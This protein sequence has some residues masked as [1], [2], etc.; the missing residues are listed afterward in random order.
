VFRALLIRSGDRNGLVALLAMTTLLPAFLV[1]CGRWLFWPFVPRFDPAAGGE[2]IADHR[3]WRRMAVLVGRRPRAVWSGTALALA[4][5]A[6]GALTLRFG[7]TQEQSFTRPVES[8][9]AQ[10]MLDGHYPGGLSAPA[11]IYATAASADAVTAAA[12]GVDGVAS[13]ALARPGDDGW[14]AIDAVLRDPADTMDAR[15]AVTRLRAAVHAVPGAQ[16]MSVDQP[17][18]PW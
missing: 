15:L 18:F 10:H 17:R 9:I 7:V 14:V 1:I 13:V 3:W 5:L 2:P 12:R 6:F 11:T 16:A 4:A 8:S